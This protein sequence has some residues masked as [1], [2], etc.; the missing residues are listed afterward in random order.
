MKILIID[1]DAAFVESL[2][3]VL[4]PTG[5]HCDGFTSPEAA[6]EA[7]RQR[8]YD[9]VLT[10]VKMPGLSGIEVFQRIL[11]LDPEAKVIIISACWDAETANTVA[12]TG[13]CALFEKPVDFLRLIE[14]LSKIE[15]KVK[16]GRRLKN[17]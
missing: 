9:V 6:L 15:A 13:A 10:D 16:E 4:E 17:E 1:D 5:Y 7:Y 8:P 11:S 12:D 3:S 2:C 14:A